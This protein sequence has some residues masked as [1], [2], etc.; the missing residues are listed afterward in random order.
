MLNILLNKNDRNKI[1]SL[2]IEATLSEDHEY[3]NSVSNYKVEEGYD[4]TDHV[5]QEPDR[6]T[7]EGVFSET[8]LPNINTDFS[9]FVK[10][11]GHS[12]VQT[13]LEALLIIAGRI[14]PKQQ[15][16][17]GTAERQLD[18]ASTLATQE[19]KVSPKVVDLITGLRIY[20]N[21][22][23]TS[24]TFSK[25]KN[26]GQSLP[27]IMGFKKIYAVESKIV[28]LDKTSDL[29]GKAPNVKNS[30]PVTKQAG[31]QVTK[32]PSSALVNIWDFLRGN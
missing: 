29:N 32:T 14:L 17:I 13:A 8:P 3:K 26:T 5:H 24:L 31:N 9:L 22:V 6:V 18:T 25:N 2:E 30:A 4:I 20:T 19:R 11:A 16:V 15:K 12:H 27:F 28:T 21:M 10:G 7:I 1:G 23:C